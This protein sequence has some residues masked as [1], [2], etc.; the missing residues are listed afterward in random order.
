MRLSFGRSIRTLWFGLGKSLLDRYDFASD[1]NGD[2]MVVRLGS[3][4]LRE[5]YESG[6]GS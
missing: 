5:P 6:A 1:Y 4:N 2:D 3:R